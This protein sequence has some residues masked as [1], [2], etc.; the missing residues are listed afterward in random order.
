[1]RQI[2]LFL[3]CLVWG[4]AVAAEPQAPP[5]ERSGVDR[6]VITEIF[7]VR[8]GIN[9]HI[10]QGYDRAYMPQ[11]K[12]GMPRDGGGPDP[13]V[14]ERNK[15]GVLYLPLSFICPFPLS[16]PLSAPIPYLPWQNCLQ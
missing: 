8:G 14:V 9:L 6:G 11:W 3:S 12:G 5:R 1:M 15:A 10:D 16:A 4:S 13:V 2:A 7:A